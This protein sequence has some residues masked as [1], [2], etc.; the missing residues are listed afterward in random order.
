MYAEER[1]QAIAELI[2][3]QGRVAVTE[4]ATQ[5]SVTTE[6]VR[7]DLS[8]LERLGCSGGCTAAPSRCARWRSSS[9]GSRERDRANTAAKDQIAARRHRPAP[10]GGSTIVVDAGSTTVRLGRAASPRPPAG[11]WSPTPSRSRPGWPACPRSTCT[12]CPAGSGRRPRRRSAPRR[13]RRSAT[14]APTSSS[15]ATNGLSAAHGLTTPDRE[16][17]ADQARH[18]R[19][20]R[21]ESSLLADSSKIGVESTLRFAASSDVDVLVTDAGIGPDDQARP[22]EGWRGSRDRMIVTLTPNPSI[23]RTVALPGRAGPRPGAARRVG[24]RAGWRQGHQHLAGLRQRRLMASSRCCRRPSDDPF[25]IELRSAG[26]DCS[27][28]RPA[29]DP[30]Q[31]HHHRARRHHH[32]AQLPRRH[33]GARVPPRRD[34]RHVAGPGR[35][36]GLG[37]ARRAR[38]RRA[39]RHGFY[40]DLVARLRGS[41]AKVAVDTS[42]APLAA[43]VDALPGA[44]PHLLKPNGE[45]L[46]SVTGGDAASLLEADPSGWRPRSPGPGRPRRRSSARHPGRQ[47]GGAR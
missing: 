10:A 27:P 39:R 29:G 32:Q 40:A 35:H 45:E 42:E 5:F 7:R 25:V 2:T 14:S 37:G 9:P 43:L 18:R 20:G 6:T 30:G 16:E 36:R 13:S 38:S 11:P 41:A 19:A 15:S 3:Q 34:G 1:H 33:G 47:R 46:A 24:H 44:A 21:R 17:A 28:V 23:D 4:L 26:I 12:C 8:P 31:P 22:R